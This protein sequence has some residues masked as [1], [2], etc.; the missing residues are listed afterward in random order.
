M[1]T[2]KPCHVK[3][4]PSILWH[5]VETRNGLRVR[6]SAPSSYVNWI[7]FHWWRQNVDEAET[8]G[9]TGWTPCTGARNMTGQHLGTYFFRFWCCWIHF[10]AS[11]KNFS[12]FQ[13]LIIVKF[14]GLE[15]SVC[16]H[17][18][19]WDFEWKNVNWILLFRLKSVVICF[20]GSASASVWDQ[21]H[22]TLRRRIPSKTIST[23]CKTKSKNASKLKN[24]ILETFWN[25]VCFVNCELNWN[26][27]K[28]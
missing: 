27:V 26:L 2:A 8:G 3:C 20:W 28:D 1:S 5:F 14:S 15:T 16:S 22:N 18:N 11:G 21:W 4:K 17:N 13:R 7:L 9:H 6:G 25:N 24:I 19:S 23:S 10:Q 12:P